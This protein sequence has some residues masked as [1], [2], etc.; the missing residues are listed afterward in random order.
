MASDLGCRDTHDASSPQLLFHPQFPP[1]APLGL[2]ERDPLSHAAA[3]SRLGKPLPPPCSLKSPCKTLSQKVAS[4]EEPNFGVRQNGTP[5]FRALQGIAAGA[6]VP[7]TS[8]SVGFPWTGYPP[9]PLP[10][11]GSHLGCA[12]RAL[13]FCESGRSIS[14]FDSAYGC[15]RCALQLVHIW[16]GWDSELRSQKWPPRKQCGQCYACRLSQ[17]QQQD[18]GLLQSGRRMLA[19]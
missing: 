12:D 5:A 17:V 2:Q 9:L 4:W 10:P 8:E 1:P 14:H 18:G 15:N 19:I 3:C 13:A 7:G 6:Q 16:P 11:V